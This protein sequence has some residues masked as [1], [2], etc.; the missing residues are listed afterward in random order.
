MSEA[1]H[2]D[3]PWAYVTSLLSG[4]AQPLPVASQSRTKLTAA[5]RLR[6]KIT[7]LERHGPLSAVVSWSDSTACCYWEQL[8]RRGRARKRGFCALTG[9]PIVAGDEVFRPRLIAPTPANIDAMILASVM[10]AM[11]L[12]EL[13]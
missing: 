5:S 9:T 7:V 3:R 11:P 1:M 8:W 12:G 13:A 4:N 10:E 2:V 6:I